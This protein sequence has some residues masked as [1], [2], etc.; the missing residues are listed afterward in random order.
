MGSWAPGVG[1]L[2]VGNVSV[3]RVVSK[4]GVGVRRWA[5][6]AGGGGGCRWG[7]GAAGRL[8]ARH[9]TVAPRGYRAPHPTAMCSTPGRLCVVGESR[10]SREPVA[11]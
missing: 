8:A 5:L 3:G 7:L 2:A 4:L 10:T 9:S 1:V 11:E 6:S